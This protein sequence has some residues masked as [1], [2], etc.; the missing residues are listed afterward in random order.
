VGLTCLASALASYGAGKITD[1]D[2]RKAAVAHGFNISKVS[3][4]KLLEFPIEKA[5]L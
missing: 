2:Y 4:D 3:G 1:Y 5:R